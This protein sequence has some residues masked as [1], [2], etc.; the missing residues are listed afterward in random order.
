MPKVRVSVSGPPVRVWVA[1]RFVISRGTSCSTIR[2]AS[3]PAPPDRGQECRDRGAE[4]VGSMG[5]ETAQRTPANA[6]KR[7]RMRFYNADDTGQTTNRNPCGDR[8][9]DAMSDTCP[10]CGADELSGIICTPVS[11]WA[12]RHACITFACGTVWH[13]VPN[14]TLR[15]GEQCLRRQLAAK[16]AKIEPLLDDLARL[17]GL[18]REAHAQFMEEEHCD[19]VKV[20]PVCHEDNIGEDFNIISAHEQG[21]RPVP[22]S[23]DCLAIRIPAELK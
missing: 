13:K 7:R 23:D 6:D 18:L 2:D 4:K 8:E 19:G 16:D 11:G 5:A 1:T 10:K 20:C 9:R 15:E 21:K 17:R 14:G 3:L 22:H 12:D